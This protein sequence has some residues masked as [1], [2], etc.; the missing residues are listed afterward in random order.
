M[1]KITVINLKNFYNGLLFS[2][3]L[4]INFIKKCNLMKNKQNLKR[5]TKKKDKLLIDLSPPRL[6]MLPLIKLVLFSFQQTKKHW[7]KLVPAL[8]KISHDKAKLVKGHGFLKLPEL[9]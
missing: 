7:L 4:Q 3:I 2:L 9:Q 1:E 6:N 5:K 8:R